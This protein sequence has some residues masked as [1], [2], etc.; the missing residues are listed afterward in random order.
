MKVLHEETYEREGNDS[1]LID[2][3][4]LIKEDGELILRHKKNH[5]G[6]AG[7]IRETIEINLEDFDT[8]EDKQNRISEY[9]ENECLTPEMEIP[10]LK[11]IFE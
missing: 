4:Q 11:T 8:I 6:W 7:N 2:K 9:I 10:N 3:I 5:K 1:W